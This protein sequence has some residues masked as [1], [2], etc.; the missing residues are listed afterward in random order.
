MGHETAVD[1]TRQN[2]EMCAGVPQVPKD[3][4][5]SPR[6]LLKVGCQLMKAPRLAA[7]EHCNSQQG[8]SSQDTLQCKD[9][10]PS[11]QALPPAEPGFWHWTATLI[12]WILGEG[13]F[14]LAP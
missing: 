14:I 8:R 13:K 12:G 4:P 2:Q 5:G 6:L 10:P 3:S 1:L 11:S 7:L 9:H